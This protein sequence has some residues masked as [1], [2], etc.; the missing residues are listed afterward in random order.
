MNS[1]NNPTAIGVDN[2]LI[3]IFGISALM[4][5]GITLT[6]IYFVIRYRR[7]KNPQPTSD[8]HGNLWLEVVW[9]LLPTLIVMTMFW[10]GWVSYLGLRNVPDGA[11]EIKCTARQ[12]SWQFEYPNGRKSAKLYVPVGQPVKVNLT[13]VDVLHSFFVP[14][15]RIKRDVV[16]GM[17]SYVWFKA[18]EPG[19]YDVFCAE[20]CGVSHSKMVTTV[21]ALNKA[22]YAKWA[23]PAV[24]NTEPRGL[25]LLKEHGCTGCHSL[26]GS[27]GVGP[28]LF[29]LNGKQIEVKTQGQERKLTVDA[30]YLRRSIREPK[31]DV[32]E[33]FQPIM[34]AFEKDQ[35]NEA[36]QQAIVDYLLNQNTQPASK[37][38][39]L[40]GQK[41]IEENGCLG[42]H[43]TDG[44][45]LA[46]PSFKG[47]G[48]RTTEVKREG[49]EIKLK[50]DAD[51]LRRALRQ[52]NYEVVDDYPAIMPTFD[53]LSDAEVEAIVQELL[54]K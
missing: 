29:Q 43:S 17:E 3:Y 2:V 13:S 34:P 47:L 25:T 19:S 15:F 21:E 42:C 38:Q 4:L 51:Y 30:D 16:P 31:A 35:L 6:M 46:G 8:V 22:D 26:D 36:D 44:S 11:L 48:T 23:Q 7:S 9:T 18:T 32:V 27:A 41:L 53:Q 40:D 39:K 50:V 14:A 52:P 10:Y 49:K 12:W 37:P 28:S 24:E 20:Y 33:G 45:R 1:L 54:K 5:V